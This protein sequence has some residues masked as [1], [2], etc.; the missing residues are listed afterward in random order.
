MEPQTEERQVHEYLV[1][2]MD[3]AACAQTVQ[4]GVATLPGVT[5]AAL[6]FT[7]AKLRISGEVDEAAV[8]ARVEQL[9]YTAQPA[10]GAV[11]P[12]SAP[13]SSGT[14]APFFA[15]MLSR[16]STRLTLLGV[17]LI[18]PGLLFD[19]LLPIFGIHVETALFGWM[20]LA[21]LAV[22]GFP[23]ARQA[24]RALRI[25]HQIT[26]NLLMTIAAVGAVIIGAWT[27]AGLVM[28][29]YALG[30]AL[31]GYTAGRARNSLQSLLEIAPDTALVL[32]PC[33]DCREHLGTGGY[34]GGACPF[35]GTE[36]HLV[37][38]DE[39][40]VGEHFVVHPGARVALDGRVVEG[41]SSLNQASITGESMPVEKR[42]GDGVYAGSINGEGALTVEATAPAA[43][44][45]IARIA[46]QVEEAQSRRAPI[47][48]TVDRFAA[49][50][51]PAVV[52][53]A[54]LVA[55]VPPL[56]WG[57]PFWGVEGWFY[58]A[59]ELLVV[60]CPCALV[61]STPVTL[62]SAVSRSARAG[63]LVKGG[64]VLQVLAGVN[65]I[66]FDK[67]GTLTQGR[68]QVVNVHSQECMTGGDGP[69]APCDDLLALAYAV[70][71]RSEH[72]LARAVADYAEQRN[73]A[74]R[75]PAA[76][77]VA[78]LPGR[79]VS[80]EVAGRKVLIGSHAW[81]DESISHPAAC[82]ELGAAARSGRTPMLLSLD[83]D[84]AGY[85]VVA[86]A[87]RPESRAALAALHDLGATTLV[88]LTGDSE[89][90]A[91]HIAAQIGIDEVQA[92][93]LPAQKV[94]AVAALK[95]RGLRVAM[96]GDGVND[97]PALATA[98][99]GVAM[100]AGTAQAIETAEVVL[101]GDNLRQLPAALRI[102][103]AAMRTVTAN[104]VFAVGIKLIFFAL[105]LVGSAT[106]WMAVLA[107]VGATMLVTLNGMRLLRLRVDE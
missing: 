92:G 86:D 49:I 1:S 105:V 90:S 37:P 58:R 30:E 50:Y 57:Q 80:G 65:A 72:P 84:Y 16:Q 87:V 42:P 53:V 85:I 11:R 69:C 45:T 13:E 63:I 38:V 93:L 28:V 70:E 20:A 106:M 99:V 78:A 7:S 74:G 52:V 33:M 59:L 56:L 3:C 2:G 98:D 101:M 29:L 82:A 14:I 107:D 44:S 31:E 19:E 81:F 96:V 103:Q 62:I 73:V 35:C 5:D 47:E 40:A 43:D 27:E 46:R 8:L 68:P 104:I 88:M 34:T 75:Y 21:A 60:A 97:A 55:I 67:T 94:D 76:T 26:I 36:E 83:D 54:F 91:R 24:W 102:A 95:L 48:R 51:T 41:Q 77:T 23:V 12:A 15:Y 64:G 71:R 25:N 100:G 79:G 61:I 89:G 66:A 32:R 17:L 9:G 18:L 4:R 39:V 6:N 22:A 10:D